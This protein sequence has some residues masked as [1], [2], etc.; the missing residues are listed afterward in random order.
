MNVQ[1]NLYTRLVQAA[2]GKFRAELDAVNGQ[3][4]QHR[5][6]RAHRPAPARHRAGRHRR[7]RARRGPVHRVALA[8]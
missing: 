7:G 1:T 2:T 3:L 6:R 4:T 8:D 5:P